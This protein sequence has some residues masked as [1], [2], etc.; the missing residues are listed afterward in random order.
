MALSFAVL[1]SHAQAGLQLSIEDLNKQYVDASSETDANLVKAKALASSNDRQ[2]YCAALQTTLDS[3]ARK[4]D[5]LQKINAIIKDRSD[6]TAEQKKEIADAETTATEGHNE[7]KGLVQRTCDQQQSATEFDPSTAVKKLSD[8]EDSGK[9]HLK[10]G[11]ALMQAGDRPM[12][13]NHMRAALKDYETQLDLTNKIKAALET[14]NDAKS[15]VIVSLQYSVGT[16]EGNIKDIKSFIA[17]S[18]EGQ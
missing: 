3:H 16:L 13:C 17:N 12:G 11:V 5:A 6:I 1:A 2:S 4:L 18:C 7:L 10:D 14:K 9:Q 15:D 8:A